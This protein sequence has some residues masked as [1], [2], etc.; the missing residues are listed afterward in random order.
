MKEILSVNVRE[1]NCSSEN[2]IVRAAGFDAV[3]LHFWVRIA[4]LPVVRKI[5]LDGDEIPVEHVFDGAEMF[6]GDVE[7]VT[8]AGILVEG[9]WRDL[10][11]RSHQLL[12]ELLTGSVTLHFEH[13]MI[14]SDL[15]DVE[16][17]LEVIRIFVVDVDLVADGCNDVHGDEFQLGDELK[18]WL[19]TGRICELILEDFADRVRLKVAVRLQVADTTWTLDH[20]RIDVDVVR[21]QQE[22]LAEVALHHAVHEHEK[23]AGLP[24]FFREDLLELV[25]E[26]DDILLDFRDE[27]GEAVV[28]CIHD[29]SRDV[30][31]V[32]EHFAAHGFTRTTNTVE[33]DAEVGVGMFPRAENAVNEVAAYAVDLFR[34]WEL[35]PGLFQIETD[36]RRESHEVDCFREEINLLAYFPKRVSVSAL[37]PSVFH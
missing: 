1:V 8:D 28:G 3:V 36:H 33:E 17:V 20:V 31:L 25:E 34:H 10:D 26:D 13:R 12:A 15:L 27:S 9:I 4:V 21:G 22:E 5:R 29:E 7:V 16:D 24:V 11:V 23:L 37:L 35:H 32:R 19:E 18:G 6:A 14:L 2:S 30:D